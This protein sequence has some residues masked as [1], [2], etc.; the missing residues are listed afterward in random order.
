MSGTKEP[1]EEKDD[2]YLPFKER[3]GK[4]KCTQCGKGHYWFERY[5]GAWVCDNDNCGHH[6]GLSRCY[7]GWGLESGERLEDDVDY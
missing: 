4:E 1:V 7:C 5:C 2:E 3:Q 6:K